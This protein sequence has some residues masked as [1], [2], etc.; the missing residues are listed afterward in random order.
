MHAESTTTCDPPDDP[1]IW[2][3]AHICRQGI[4]HTTRCGTTRRT[5]AAACRHAVKRGATSGHE[6]P[7]RVECP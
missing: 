5:F 6:Y 4:K 3:S 2:Q 7:V 1:A